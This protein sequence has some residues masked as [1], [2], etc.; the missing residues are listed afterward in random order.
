MCDM[1]RA[2]LLQWGIAAGLAD[3]GASKQLSKWSHSDLRLLVERA[4]NC[5]QMILTDT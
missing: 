3:G 4:L 5:V 2:T 1:P